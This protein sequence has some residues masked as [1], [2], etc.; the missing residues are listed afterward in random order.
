MFASYKIA[1]FR[2]FFK[3]SGQTEGQKGSNQKPRQK[4]SRRQKKAPGIY[5]RIFQATVEKLLEDLGGALVK[6][7]FANKSGQR[8]FVS[9][10]ALEGIAGAV[11]FA[12]NFLSDHFS[13]DSSLGLHI[14]EF[15]LHLH[16]PKTLDFYT[17]TAFLSLLAIKVYSTF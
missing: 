6:I 12:V 10:F 7:S 3:H 8:T 13:F 9:G 17:A 16:S 14:I 5:R 2:D 1:H 15:P 11:G 4:K